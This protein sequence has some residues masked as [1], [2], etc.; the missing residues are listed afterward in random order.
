MESN[1]ARSGHFNSS[2]R[3]AA[4]PLP[5]VEVELFRN[6][7]E[8]V[9]RESGRV[10]SKAALSAADVQRASHRME[11]VPQLQRSLCPDALSSASVE[12]I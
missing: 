6:G 5:P 7:V 11:A 8:E 3:Q 2:P 10:A 9:D 4:S 12:I 1:V